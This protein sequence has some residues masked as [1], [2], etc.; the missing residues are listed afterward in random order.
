V[1]K[2]EFRGFK[3]VFLFEFM[4]GIKKTG[5]KI[6]LL[7]I[8]S[9]SFL[10]MPV[11]LILDNNKADDDAKKSAPVKAAIESVYIYDNTDLT[12][13]YSLLNDNEKYTDVSFVTDSDISYTDAI[14]NLKGNSDHKDLVIGIEYEAK[15]G[16]DITITDSSKSEISDSDL[17]SFEDDYLSFYRE[18][19]LKNLDISQEDYE[20]LTQNIHV[21]VMKIDESG[22]VANNEE[23]IS[24]NEYIIMLAG[25]MA[26]FMFI[27]MSVG[28]VATSIA[29]EKSSRVIE[30]LLTGTRPLA[31]LS[32]KI[33]ARLLENVIILFAAYSSYFMS[34]LVCVFLIA[35]NASGS[36]SSNLVVVSSFWDTI[37]IP[38]L[39]LTVL[40]FLAGLFLFTILGAIAGAS[41]SKLDELQDAYKFYSFIMIVCVYVDMFIIIMMLSTS[42]SSSF[43]NFCALFPFTGAFITPALI[44]TGKLSVFTG[45]IA[46]IIIVITAVLAFILASAVYESMLLFQ[47]KRLKAKDI[48]ALMKK[49][50]V[51]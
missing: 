44:L 16:F 42:I 50:V 51:E 1:N 8:C 45:T 22:S 5:F 12:I 17:S 32:G 26:V 20:Y 36:T 11:M 23:G 35:G 3:Q 19:I 40:Y 2:N 47:G 34:Q 9:I 7:V 48:I 27:N 28:N 43:E 21:N 24:Y 31:L 14:E 6:F 13:D 18:E 38:K 41:V 30:Y 29:T 25:L 33:A 15:E 39:V 46:L 49:Q 10:A 37:T 4:T